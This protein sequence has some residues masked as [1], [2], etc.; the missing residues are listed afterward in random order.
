MHCYHTTLKHSDYC[1]RD[2][3]V[4]SLIL[5]YIFLNTKN[6]FFYRKSPLDP[7]IKFWPDMADTGG[8]MVDVKEAIPTQI[9][10]KSYPNDQLA[11]PKF[12]PCRHG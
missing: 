2:E 6:G 12:T 1:L 4:A 10:G 5:N 8:N 7:G 11:H 9:Y 3:A